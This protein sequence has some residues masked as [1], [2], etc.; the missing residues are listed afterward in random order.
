MFYRLKQLYHAL[1]PKIGEKEY[2]WLH[3][4]LSPQELA[5]FLQQA[6]PEQRH[7]LDVAYD[8]MMQK[9]SVETIF[10]NRQY[11]NLF[12]AAL[13][14]DCGKSQYKL[15]LLQRIFIVIAGHFPNR[16]QYFLLN[17]Q[18]ILGQTLTLYKEHPSLGK[19]FAVQAGMN[20]EIQ[21]LIEMHHDPQNSLGFLLFE[22]DNRH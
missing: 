19:L 1:F 10:G 22:A 12:C 4:T 15:N 9:E 3:S 11:W 20:E 13:F 6:L 17:Q 8:I 18:N 7:A 14:H 16:W 2:T 5:L 21:S